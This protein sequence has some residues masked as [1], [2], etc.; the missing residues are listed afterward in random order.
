VA[1][2]TASRTIVV[3]VWA[4]WRIFDWGNG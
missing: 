2:P 1:I 4:G 3:G